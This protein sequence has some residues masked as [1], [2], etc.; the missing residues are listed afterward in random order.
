M[1]DTDLRVALDRY[2]A[3]VDAC[4]VGRIS[5]A[6]FL[7]LYDNFYMTYALEGQYASDDARELLVHYER[8]I[9]IHREI[10]EQILT[11]V[12]GDEEARN[13]DFIAAGYIG[14][15]EATVRLRQLALMYLPERTEG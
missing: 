15:R 10:W 9:A 8:R 3:I 6:Q 7:E 4:A 5:F 13:P 11:R 14:S 2:D 1:N 12:C